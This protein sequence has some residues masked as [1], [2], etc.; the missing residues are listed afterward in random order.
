MTIAIIQ[1]T[2]EEF[3]TITKRGEG[4]FSDIK[5]AAI[6]PAKLTNSMS[7]FANA[8]GGE[9]FIGIDESPRGSFTWNGFPR[10]EDANGHVQAF[11]QFF[12]LGSDFRYQFL[13]LPGHFGLVLHCEIDKTVDVRSASS[14]DIY[15]RRGAQ[16]LKQSTFDQ[17]NRIRLNKGISSYEDFSLNVD[18]SDITK[19]AVIRSFISDIVPLTRPEPWLRKQHLIVN[20]RPVVA[21]LLLFSDEPQTGIPKATIKIY[22]Y[23]TS[24]ANGT[25]ETL[26]FNP[27]SIEG[28]AYKQIFSAV[29]K[30]RE[31]IEQI[32][33]AA[34]GGIQAIEYPTEAIHEI[35]TNAVIHRDYSLNDDIHI[36]IF[37]NRIEVVSP[38][39]LPAHVTA[40]NI[41]DER[42]ARN[43]KIVRLISKFKNPPN[44]D[45]GEGL[46][47][48]FEAM[49]KLKLKD[50]FIEQRDASVWVILK[51]ERLGTP[52]NAI[53][54]F[55][56]DHDEI[57]NAK[58]RAI[59][60]IGSENTMKRILQKMVTD[61][62][63]ERIPNRPLNK[64]GY[65][66]G[67]SFPS[68]AKSGA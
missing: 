27:I 57:N 56:M 4:H 13:S 23:K 20:Q 47:T 51:H 30:V 49:R 6:S 41:L 67:P 36:R 40:E 16:N 14:G 19:S 34:G 53:I 44:K 1:I 68:R 38:G 12:P 54:E 39:T 52:E 66:K 46:N 58:A 2:V 5:A 21:G 26:A 10:V 25:R 15:I 42:F 8:D 43:P 65:V 48:A 9:L 17:I 32:P 11:E 59:C 50:P 35:T 28:C 55:L 31:I 7:A 24:Q 29:E 33:V 37:D 18:I 45:V 64:T 22:R 60:Y 61:R 63:I 3:L 62:I